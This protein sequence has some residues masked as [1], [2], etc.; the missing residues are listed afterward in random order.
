MNLAG[1]ARSLD[2]APLEAFSVLQLKELGFTPQE[3]EEAFDLAALMGMNNTYYKFKSALPADVIADP[4]YARIGLRNTSM[5]QTSI[6][7][8][9][10]ETIAFTVSV[11]NGCPSCMTAHEKALTNLGVS[12]E[13]IHDLARLASVTKGLSHIK[14]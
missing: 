6:G 12:R 3:T 1:I 5:K 9:L 7:Q 11:I 4:A 8:H 13:K 14:K 2:W 10:T